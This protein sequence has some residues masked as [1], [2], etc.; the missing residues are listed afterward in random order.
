MTIR[1]DRR[2]YSLPLDGAPADLVALGRT[3]G[4]WLELDD[5]PAAPHIVWRALGATEFVELSTMARLRARALLAEQQIP[6]DTTIDDEGT[7]ASQQME[8]TVLSL[9]AAR[10]SVVSVH[11]GPAG[12]A[13]PGA[14]LD[15]LDPSLPISH[16]SRVLNATLAPD[17]FAR[18]ASRR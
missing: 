11:G 6:A 18:A 3:E 9:M 14:Y 5:P 10:R 1:T 13:S 7:T 2:F 8:R 16:G 4:Q 17:P 12:L 15:T